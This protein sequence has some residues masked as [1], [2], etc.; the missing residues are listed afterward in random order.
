[1]PGSGNRPKNNIQALPFDPVTLGESLRSISSDVLKTESHDLVS[2]WYQSR[3]DLNLFIW[4][5]ENGTIIRQQLSFFG[6]V[7]DWNIIEGVKTGAVV[8]GDRPDAVDASTVIKLDAKPNPIILEQA[9][10]I[11]SR[12]A[13]MPDV[14]RGQCEINWYSSKVRGLGTFEDFVHHFKKENDKPTGLWGRILA[15]VSGRR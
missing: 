11:T 12:V 8:D 4:K 9:R 3:Y 10:E 2:Q 5:D 14:D 15:W 7:A 13:A 6:L 1:M